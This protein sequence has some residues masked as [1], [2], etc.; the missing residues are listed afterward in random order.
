MGSKSKKKKKLFQRKVRRW[1]EK[2]ADHS[3]I[4]PK[5]TRKMSL[6]NRLTTPKAPIIA[7][8]TPTASAFQVPGLNLGG[9][10]LKGT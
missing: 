8:T 1:F 3:G 9:S 2:R 5:K 6:Q 10:L 7:P 4:L